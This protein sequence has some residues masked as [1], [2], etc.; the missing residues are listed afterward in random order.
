LQIEAALIIGYRR[1]EN[2]KIISQSCI[3][4]G[5]T[6][7]Y[8][9]LDMVD[10]NDLRAVA[11]H[12][13]CLRVIR[14]LELDSNLKVV[15]QIQDSNVGCA[16]A[17]VSGCDWFFKHETFGVVLED[18]CIPSK[19]FFRYV[20]DSAGF[21]IDS[22]EI[23]LISGSQVCKSIE[24]L[25]GSYVSKYA[26]IWG[27]A[28]NSD[29]WK[30]IS[31]SL[32]VRPKKLKLSNIFS[33]EYSYWYFGAKRAET[34]IVDAWDTILLQRMHEHGK[35]SIVPYQ[36]LVQNVGGDEFAVHTKSTDLV[37]VIAVGDYW[38]EKFPA[39]DLRADERLRHDFYKIS[40]RHLLTTRVHWLLD[41]ALILA[42]RSKYRTLNHRLNAAHAHH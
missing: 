10:K 5:I 4:A 17:V 42:Q 28:T 2:L 35:L 32:R 18:D 12:E 25:S 24:S 16:V 19:A 41:R 30:E 37:N 14:V 3:A 33:P 40:V 1:S 20:S 31:A 27:W 36:N 29:K 11:D 22:P 34:G 9:S 23:W 26:L 15:L 7:L 38:A 39:R 13:A 8:F 21:L 6:R